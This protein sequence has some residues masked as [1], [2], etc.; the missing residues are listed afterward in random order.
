[1]SFVPDAP[2]DP[3]FQLHHT[4][5]DRWVWLWQQRGGRMR[6]TRGKWPPLAV[7][8]TCLPSLPHARPAQQAMG[9]RCATC[10]YVQLVMCRS[11]AAARRCNC[12]NCQV[13]SG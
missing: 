12:M 6:D 1:M 4:N 2:L 8:A 10:S 13:N 5:G 7:A 3:C 11:I 9:M